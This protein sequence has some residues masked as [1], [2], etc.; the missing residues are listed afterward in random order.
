MVMRTV[1]KKKRAGRRTG[2]SW[3]PGCGNYRREAQQNM[4]LAEGKELWVPW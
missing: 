2:S 4:R 1:K 3:I